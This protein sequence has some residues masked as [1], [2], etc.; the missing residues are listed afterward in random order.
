[1]R[2]PYTYTDPLVA[3]LE[4]AKNSIFGGG[5]SR[6]GESLTS[7]KGGPADDAI[8]SIGTFSV[9]KRYVSPAL[10]KQRLP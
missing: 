6:E 4:R 9:G 3:G 10:S 5:P 2:S 8:L 1:M 7:T